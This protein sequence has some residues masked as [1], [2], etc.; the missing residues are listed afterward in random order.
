MWLLCTSLYS[1]YIHCTAFGTAL[2]APGSDLGADAIKT[3]MLPNAE[4]VRLVAERV[5]HYRSAS[6]QAPPPPLPLPLVVD[7]VLVSTSGHSLAEGGVAAALLEE[8]LPLATVATPNLP[9]AEALLGGS[10]VGWGEDVVGGGRG[11]G[12]GVGRGG[13]ARRLG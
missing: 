12:W 4:T 5:R 10:G 9:E 3:G 13:G 6:R 11:M 8:L 1:S 7:P 2:S